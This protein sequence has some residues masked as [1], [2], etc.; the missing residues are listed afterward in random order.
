VPSTFDYLGVG[1]EASVDVLGDP[2]DERCSEP[3]GLCGD[4]LALDA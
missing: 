1:E 3:G 4:L 2:D